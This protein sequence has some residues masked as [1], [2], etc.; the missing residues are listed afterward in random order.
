MAEAQLFVSQDEFTCSVCLDTLTEPV[1]IPCGHNFCLKCLTDCWDQSQECSCPQCRE[2]FTTRPALRR[3]NLLNEVIKK[4]KKTTLSSPSS[5]NFAG[6]GDVEC[7]FCTGKKFRAVKSCLTC[8]ASYCRTHLQPHYEGEAW[9][10]HK[11][12]D[13]DRNLKE[14]LCVKHQKSLEMFCR[15]DEMCICLMCAVT[16]HDGH[17]KVELETEREVKQKQLRATQ[18]EIRR[19]LEDKEKKLKE[20]R[21]AME[22]MKIS[23]ERMMG[24][25]EKSFTDLIHCIE[26]AHK[27]LTE[28]ITEQEKKE[29]EKA[30]EVMEK[31]KKE[32]EELKRKEAE[33]K[34][35]SETKDLLHFLQTLSSRCVLPADGDSLSFTVT[36]DFS[37]EDLVKELSCLKK[38]LEKI[39]EQDILLLTP[40]GH[41]APV[42]TLRP[43]EPQSREEFLQYFCP[44]T[45]DINTAHRGLRLSEGNKKVT[46][47]GT[48]AKYPDHPDRFDCYFQVLCREALT[49]TRCY[50]E[51]ECSGNGVVIGVAYKGL[52]RKGQGRKCGIGRNDKSWCLLWSHSQYSVWHNN[53]QTVISAPY[54]PRI[55]V[56][57]DWPAGSLS[58]YSVSHTM[59]L[60]H[61][62]NTSF[63]EPLY[64][65]FGFNDFCSVTICHLTPCDH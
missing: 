19:R 33:L 5:Q 25:N 21:R 8:P 52:G 34:E 7:D 26:E 3:N 42:F 54:R 13:P 35:L 61:R 62:F 4:L 49:G 2:N 55:G 10:G 11:L 47:E 38:S 39:S 30:E 32:I 43:P 63:T 15:N 24:E 1:T 60:L 16:E 27:K 17:E 14:K 65:G 23:V 18:S 31:L 64:R 48:K 58:F 53:Q 41:E 40:S 51:V 12:V 29:M 37:S 22:D 45:L 36:T 6:P 57:L 9:K 44:L 28:R 56:Y 20:T 59:T 46:Y 50:W